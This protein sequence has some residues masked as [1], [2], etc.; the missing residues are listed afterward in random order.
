MRV[1]CF[2]HDEEPRGLLIKP[3][4]NPGPFH[5]ADARETCAVREERVD[6]RSGVHATRRM[7]Q[8]PRRFVDN[9]EVSILVKDVKRNRFRLKGFPRTRPW[10]RKTEAVPGSEGI[11][12]LSSDFTVDSD[13][14]LANQFLERGA[15]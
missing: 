10:N 15:G 5:T 14:P 12:G 1:I 7:H 11:T 8:H 6:E 13:G 3:M 9:Y 4:H 2:R